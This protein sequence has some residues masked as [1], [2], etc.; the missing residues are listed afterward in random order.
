M[1]KADL[2][3][4][5]AVGPLI[6]AEPYAKSHWGL[7]LEDRGCHVPSDSG[8]YGANQA[9]LAKL[10]PALRCAQATDVETVELDQVA[11]LLGFGIERDPKGR[12][13]RLR[14]S[15]VAGDQAQPPLTGGQAP[16]P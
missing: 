14:R 9:D 15:S 13:F 2:L 7:L 4:P 16:A 12:R 5:V 1:Q 10:D 8:L 6:P 3:F 11:G